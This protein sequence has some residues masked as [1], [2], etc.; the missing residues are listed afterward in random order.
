[1]IL[2]RTRKRKAAGDDLPVR[3]LCQIFNVLRL[4]FPR[5]RLQ[6]AKTKGLAADSHPEDCSPYILHHRP[7]IW[8][9]W[10]PV[11]MGFICGLGDDF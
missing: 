8:P 4:T 11:D 2:R 6:A 9:Y 1:M 10:W 7:P 5:Y 3:I